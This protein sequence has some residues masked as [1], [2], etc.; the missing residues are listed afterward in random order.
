MLNERKLTENELEQRKIA[1]KGLLKN[2]RALVKKYGKDAEKVMYGIATKQ[3]KKK[4]ENMNLENLRG[5]IQDALKNPKKADLNKDGKLSDYEEKRGAAIEKNIK[6]D[7]FSNAS[8]EDVFQSIKNLA[9]TTGMG[10]QEAAETA[11]DE[12]RIEFGVDAFY[13]SLDE[14]YK[15]SLRAYNVID[16]DGNIVY[17][18]LPREKAIEKA[19]EREDYKFTATDSLAE[20]KDEDV[21]KY[22]GEDHVITRRD[23]DRIYLRRKEDAAILGKMPEFWV[24]SQDINEDLD[25]GH[26]DNE[27]HMLK[28]DVYRIAKYAAE[29]YKMLDKYDKMEGEVD[30][31]HWWQAKIIKARDLM[32]SAKHYLDGEEKISQI[33]AMMDLEPMGGINEVS[34]VSKSRAG[35]E[36]KQ[37][38]KGTRS[39]GMGKHNAIVYGLD[40][41]G[42]RVELKSLNDLNK[43]SKFE[44]DSSLDENL[45][46][47]NTSEFKV[48]DK[49]TYL[50]HPAKITA[51]KE[52]N[53]RNF[54][55]VSYD[56]GNGATKASM[57]LTTS[58]DVKLAE[59]SI[60]ERIDYDEA[61]N[62]RA[63]KAELKDE[64]KQLFTDMEAEGD[65]SKANEYG[66]KLNKLEDKLEK[67]E[68]QLDDYDMNESVNENVDVIDS[69]KDKMYVD[70]GRFQTIIHPLSKP[71]VRRPDKSFI[72]VKDSNIIAIQGY[73]S[74]PIEDFVQKYKFA[75][76]SNSQFDLGMEVARGTTPL[77]Q[78]SLND[79]IKAIDDARNAEAKKQRDYY[80]ARGPVSGIGNMDE[81]I[82]SIVKE[83]LTKKSSVKKHIEDFK[84]SDAPQFKGKS[85]DKKIQMAVASF[86][87][88]Q[89]KSVKENMVADEDIEKEIKQL[90]DENPKGFAKEISMLK[91]RQAVVNLM[92]KAK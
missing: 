57:I 2:K 15:P 24:K 66:N 70:A 8:M 72:I 54:V 82:K 81:M 77:T 11:I 51:T 3:A 33:D 41:D 9:H 61:L 59:N 27:P 55:S 63:I 78:Q 31:P 52:Y 22:K 20:D 13:E 84:D 79:A 60:D 16:G 21:V 69:I 89:G 50:G 90:E 34:S 14:D 86:L 10:E 46:E 83:K 29:L 76:W 36:L 1:L 80:Q 88:K 30:F 25:V 6:E 53:G 28:S 75:D 32:V 17:K 92:K 23:G 62:L 74:G 38:L 5:I 4:V 68:K 64:I 45:D 7:I 65:E 43:Y 71:D 58:G 44:L 42:K 56:K 87:S 18:E 12:I 37:R 40:S 67:V 85:D 35:A 39:D 48:G 26:E 47:A 49:V 73:N 19:G 91:V